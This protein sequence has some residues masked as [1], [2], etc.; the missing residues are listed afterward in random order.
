MNGPACAWRLN[1][2]PSSRGRLLE[3]AWHSGR[4][5]RASSASSRNNS[6]GIRTAPRI[7]PAAP[8]RAGGLGRI[9][10]RLTPGGEPPPDGDRGSSGRGHRQHG[11][12]G[13]LG[14]PPSFPG[15]LYRASSCAGSDSAAPGPRPD[16]SSSKGTFPIVLWPPP[17]SGRG[18]PN[19]KLFRPFRRLRHL[20][21]PQQSALPGRPKPGCS[22][23]IETSAGGSRRTTTSRSPRP[24]PSMPGPQ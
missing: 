23:P 8:P 6:S 24:L 20:L 18:F 11:G 19:R 7:L 10:A 14:G 21:Y 2:L 1:P 22:E 5:R 15:D 17:S 9:S 16:G 4:P 3:R 12:R 13:K